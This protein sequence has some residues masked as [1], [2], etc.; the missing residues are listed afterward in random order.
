MIPVIRGYLA[1]GE[2][3]AGRSEGTVN[4]A[5]GAVSVIDEDRQREVFNYFKTA[6]SDSA[7]DALS[8]LGENDYS[9]DDIRLM[10][11]KFMSELGN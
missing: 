9:L 7:E 11:I 4:I 2:K 3:A 5:I 6:E 8:E 10:R 1:G